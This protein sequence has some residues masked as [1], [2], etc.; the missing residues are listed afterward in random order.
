MKQA[1]PTQFPACLLFNH[2]VGFVFMAYLYVFPACSAEMLLTLRCKT[3][4]LSILTGSVQ[5][6]YA[7]D[8]PVCFQVRSFCVDSLSGGGG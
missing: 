3:G 5:L 6:G 1:C 2:L 7:Y 4:R 8:R